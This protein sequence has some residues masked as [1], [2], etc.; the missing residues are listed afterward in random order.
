MRKFGNPA[1]RLALKRKEMIVADYLFREAPLT[2]WDY[3]PSTAVSNLFDAFHSST[4]TSLFLDMLFPNPQLR[5]SPRHILLG[6]RWARQVVP[7]AS[8]TRN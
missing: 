1:T 7:Q 5:N 6:S 2:N 8:Q 3:A 4:P